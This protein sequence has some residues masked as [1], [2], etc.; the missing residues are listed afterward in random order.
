MA[1]TGLPPTPEEID[2]EE[3]RDI[4]GKLKEVLGLMTKGCN[5]DDTDERLRVARERRDTNHGDKTPVFHITP[6]GHTATTIHT[7]TK[8]A[9]AE[10]LKTRIQLGQ[11]AKKLDDTL[12]RLSVRYVDVLERILSR[13]RY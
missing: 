4:E 6:Q 13:A 9:L 3:L 12:E 7:H 11:Y 2:Q 5:R 8:L 1:S 10:E